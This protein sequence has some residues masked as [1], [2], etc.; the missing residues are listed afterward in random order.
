MLPKF[1]LMHVALLTALATV[2]MAAEAK[3]PAST[4][5]KGDDKNVS[6][7]ITNTEDELAD[8]GTAGTFGDTE[9][10]LGPEDQIQFFVWKEP[11]LSTT[12]VVRPDGKI[13]LPLIGEI[14]AVGKTARQLQD[15]TGKRLKQ[16][17]TTPVVSVIV[18]QVNSPKISVLGQVRRPDQ[19]RIKQRLTVLDAIALAG[20]FTEYADGDKVV[21]IRNGKWGVQRIKLNL[22]PLIK[23][24]RSSL[25]YVQPAD[26][27]YVE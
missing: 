26:T 2:G 16:F 1:T 4:K 7:E 25:A 12:V 9:Y 6:V 13:S 17:V 8:G 11:D 27:V 18:T 24:G 3:K 21:I 23:N 20:G 14:E 19:Y 15:E 22:K 5:A 10:R